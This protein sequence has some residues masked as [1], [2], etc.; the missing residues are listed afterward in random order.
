MQDACRGQLSFLSGVFTL[1]RIDGDGH[2]V[3]WPACCTAAVF[4]LHFT[5]T[6]LFIFNIPTFP[7]SFYSTLHVSYSFTISL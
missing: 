3:A 5:E 6:L 4:A 2:V 7:T 1:T